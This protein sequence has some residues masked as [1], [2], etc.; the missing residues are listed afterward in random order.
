M[1]IRVYVARLPHRL[2]LVAEF[3]GTFQELLDIPLSPLVANTDRLVGQFWHL[4]GSNEMTLVIGRINDLLCVVSA[5]EAPFRS[6]V[7]VRE[8]R[9]N[10]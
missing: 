4:V 7:A 10:A 3:T 5:R 1:R 8:C 2:N 9:Q 6:A